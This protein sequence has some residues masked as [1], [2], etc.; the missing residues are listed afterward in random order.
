MLGPTRGF[1]TKANRRSMF[2]AASSESLPESSSC[3][4]QRNDVAEER[5]EFGN[6]E[7]GER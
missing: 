4:E 2:S 6:P 7:E 3:V 5:E 1:F